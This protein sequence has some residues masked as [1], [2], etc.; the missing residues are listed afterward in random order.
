LHRPP[1]LHPHARCAFGD[2]YGHIVLRHRI[3]IEDRHGAILAIF[4]FGDVV[5][6]LQIPEDV[7]TGLSAVG[8]R[9]RAMMGF[10]VRF[11]RKSRDPPRALMVTERTETA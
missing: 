1:N 2:G 5:K 4:H 3:E 6:I 7:K 11:M 9:G 10:Y 8:A